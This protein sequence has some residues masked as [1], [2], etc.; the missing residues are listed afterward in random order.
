MMTKRFLR[1]AGLIAATALTMGALAQDPDDDSVQE[2]LTAVETRDPGNYV[3]DSQLMALYT[4]ADAP[5]VGELEFGPGSGGAASGGTL[6]GGAASGGSNAEQQSLPCTGECLE[7]WPPLTVEAGTE[8][9]VNEAL[10]PELVG[11]TELE[12][13]TVQVTYAGWPLYYFSEDEEAGDLNGMGIEAF[14]GTWYMVS[15]NNGALLQS[16]DAVTN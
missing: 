13:G 6:S 16:P 5:N 1:T 3:A 7:A 8:P 2:T 4:L 14:G 11:T 12:D 10:N 9:T 15:S